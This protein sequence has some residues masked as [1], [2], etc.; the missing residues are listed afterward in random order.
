MTRSSNWLGPISF[1]DKTA[2]F[3]S[4][5]GYKLQ[6]S[7]NVSKKVTTVTVEKKRSSGT[8]WAYEVWSDL[9]ENQIITEKDIGD[10]IQVAG[11][12]HPDPYKLRK[13]VEADKKTPYKE[14]CII[15]ADNYGNLRTFY[16]TMCRRHPK[17]LAAEAKL[18]QK[19]KKKRK[20][21]CKLCGELF[22][23]IN[24][25]LKKTHDMTPEEY[26]NESKTRDKKHTNK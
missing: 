16:Y 12:L 14:R 6:P 15:A 26:Q 20:V 13:I 18:A 11:D 7:K 1:K 17:V 21:R 5:T 2:G 22:F 25:H 4:P 19:N 24:A 8:S 9:P 23:R 3:K 10:H